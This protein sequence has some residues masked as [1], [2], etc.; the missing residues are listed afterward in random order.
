M[1]WEAIIFDCDGVLVD[2]EPI[3]NRVFH[4]HLT[5]IGLQMSIEETM[6]TFVGRSMAS[7]VEIIEARL[8]SPVPEGFL[9]RLDAETLAALADAVEAVPG[10]EAALDAITCTTAVASSGSHDKMRVTLMRT[11]LRS[12]FSGRIF[13]ATD[14][15]VAR[16]KPHPDLFLYAARR[17]GVDPA[18]CAVIEDSLPGVEAAVAAGM[19]AFGFAAR[20]P[21]PRLA[22]AGAVVFD[23]MH[24]L[25]D[26]LARYAPD[27]V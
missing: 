21:S 1:G 17:L 4:K 14:A 27:S 3:S 24:R 25:P 7:C 10:I 11:G 20:A 6:D 2:S 12:R 15:E 19:R 23:D 26:L 13:S 8:G 16:G 22:A 9:A 5:A 18:R